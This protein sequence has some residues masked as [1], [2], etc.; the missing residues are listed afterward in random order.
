MKF[1]ALHNR[2]FLEW[3]F[4]PSKSILAELEAAESD[5]NALTRTESQEARAEFDHTHD[6]QAPTPDAA[7]TEASSA[8]A[9]TPANTAPKPTTMAERMGFPRPG[10]ARKS[11][12]F[13][14]ITRDVV[15]SPA[16]HSS[17]AQSY[18]NLF[19]GHTDD[20]HAADS[21][22]KIDVRLEKLN[23][24]YSHSKILF[25]FVGPQ[26][27]GITNA[28]KLEIGLLTSLPL[29]KEIVKDL[30]EGKTMIPLAPPM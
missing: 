23:E 1:D 6:G 28:E 19:T 18:F 16:L 20:T 14:A 9:S 2:Q 3:V 5:V 26:E 11:N 25:D 22:A 10:G 15:S 17:P 24:L 30:E 12:D 13:N 7:S 29:L 4:T 8:N 21:K 27:Y